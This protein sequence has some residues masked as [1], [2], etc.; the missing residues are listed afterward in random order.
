M[1]SEQLG[2]CL[3]S[4]QSCRE[5]NLLVL[6]GFSIPLDISRPESEERSS[7]SAGGQEGLKGFAEA[8]GLCSL[9]LGTSSIC[10]FITAVC[11]PK[12]RGKRAG[13]DFL[14]FTFERDSLL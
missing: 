4:W 6:N 13:L 12:K 9:A 8:C 11:S 7:N 1:V 14:C 2:K 5:G 3:W 10:P